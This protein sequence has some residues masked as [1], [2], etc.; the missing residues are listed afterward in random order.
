MATVSEVATRRANNTGCLR[1][2]GDA[3]ELRVSSGFKADGKPILITRTFR[4]TRKEAE[5]ALMAMVLEYGRGR[6]QGSLST[7]DEMVAQSIRMSKLS[8]TTLAEYRRAADRLPRSLASMPVWKVR[9]LDLERAYDELARS[10]H[11]E[12]SVRRVH[13]V[14]SSA[15]GRAVRWGWIEK[16]PAASARPP[17]RPRS[18]VAAVTPDLIRRILDAAPRPVDL[19]IRLTFISGAR[20]GEICALR[21]DDLDGARLVIRRN[22]VY[23]PA[24]GLVVKT[25]KTDNERY[26]MLDSD[27]VAMLE[28]W[29]AEQ[30]RVIR[31]EWIFTH[32]SVSPWRPDYIGL[33][34]RR[35][36]RKVGVDFR[37]HSMRHAAASQLLDA[38][39]PISAVS[40][41]L[42]HDR[43]STTLNIYSHTLAGRDAQAA[44]HL[45]SL[46]T[47]G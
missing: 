24:S 10:G 6:D 44:D 7:V 45:A 26:L 46:L 4:G 28:A 21:W 19:W 37:I 36:Q 42:G 8:P 2:R 31:S 35:I 3:W 5:M 23:T 27:T 40:S 14:L 17:A 20:R 22:V 11:S 13:E 1:K 30:A 34:I 32:D 41:R 43:E 33:A 39:F 25:T 15:F 18:S 29:R 9:P 16:S 38:G 12:H 47:P